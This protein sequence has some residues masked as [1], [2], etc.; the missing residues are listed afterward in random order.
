MLENIARPGRPTGDKLASV[1]WFDED[2]ILNARYM[3]ALDDVR[4]SRYPVPS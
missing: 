2:D 4:N 3:A 1:D